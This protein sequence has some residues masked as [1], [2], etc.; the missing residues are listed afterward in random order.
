VSTDIL[1][2]H[3]PPRYH[4]DIGLGCSG[5]LEEAWRVK[6]RLHVFGHI[7]AAHGREAVFWDNGQ[8]AFERLMARKNQGIIR[9]LLPSL[10]WLDAL[11]V[12]WYGVR[13][14]LWQHLMVGSTGANGG[15]L[16]N[17]TLVSWKTAD[18]IGHR[19]EV[20]EL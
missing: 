9:D 17:A 10:A 1:I 12:I 5:L 7:H 2:T 16:V 6:P 19:A 15:L 20:V 18:I 4:L 8:A 3:T 13:G 11:K 14:I